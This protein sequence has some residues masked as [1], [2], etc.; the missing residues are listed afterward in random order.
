MADINPFT[1]RI[2]RSRSFCA[3]SAG[4]GFP[5]GLAAVDHV[6]RARHLAS[7]DRLLKKYDAE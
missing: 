5:I 3:V 2:H 6:F 7:L 1:R 4:Q